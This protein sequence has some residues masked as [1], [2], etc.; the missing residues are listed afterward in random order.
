MIDD[1]TTTTAPTPLPP[2][3]PTVCVIGG[4]PGAMFFCHSLETQKNLLLDEGEDISSFPTI[5]KCFER[6]SGPGGVWRS[7]RTHGDDKEE[8]KKE[9]ES[10][11]G[12]LLSDNIA[13][14]AITMDVDNNHINIKLVL[15]S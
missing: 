13:A 1:A 5:V 6:S 14:T 15:P 11:N 10:E 8:V 9:N 2:P 12:S 7:D 3:P 4:G